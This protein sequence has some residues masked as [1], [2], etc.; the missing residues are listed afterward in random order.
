MKRLL[1]V[2]VLLSAGAVQA[3]LDLDDLWSEVSGLTVRS[4]DACYVTN[5]SGAIA[6]SRETLMFT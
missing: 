1:C 5:A 3:E 6:R 2:I 4:S